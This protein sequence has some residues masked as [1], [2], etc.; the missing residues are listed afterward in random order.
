MVAYVEIAMGIIT[1]LTKADPAYLG[2]YYL[3]ISFLALGPYPRKV[4]WAI[5]AVSLAGFFAVG[6]SVSI[7][8]SYYF[9]K[10]SV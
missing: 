4:A 3:V 2:G 10:F 1:G 8:C 6:F 9:L 7:L 5:L